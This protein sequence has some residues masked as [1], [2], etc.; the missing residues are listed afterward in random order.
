MKVILS[1]LVAAMILSV[2]S[3]AMVAA[4]LARDVFGQPDSCVL[5]IFILLSILYFIV[6][7]L[8]DR[9]QHAK[10]PVRG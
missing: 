5:L 4:L 7:F 9:L 6:L 3:I 2:S 10:K 1:Y 8:W